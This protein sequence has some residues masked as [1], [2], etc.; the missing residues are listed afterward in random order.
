MN[1]EQRMSPFV[2]HAIQ[3]EILVPSARPYECFLGVLNPDAL[4]MTSCH[5]FHSP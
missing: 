3:R 1:I 4:L 2:N 5:L